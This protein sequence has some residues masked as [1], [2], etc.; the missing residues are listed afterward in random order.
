MAWRTPQDREL[1][2]SEHTRN[3][4]SQL[5]SNPNVTRWALQAFGKAACTIVSHHRLHGQQPKKNS[6]TKAG[7]ECACRTLLADISATLGAPLPSPVS[8]AGTLLCTCSPG[9]VCSIKPPSLS[10]TCCCI[11]CTTNAAQHFT[12][13]M[14]KHPAC[15]LPASLPEHPVRLHVPLFSPCVGPTVAGTHMLTCRLLQSEFV[16]TLD[17]QYLSKRALQQPGNGSPRRLGPASGGEAAPSRNPPGFGT[18]QGDEPVHS[19]SLSGFGR[20]QGAHAVHSGSPLGFGRL[21]AEDATS[22]L[23][24]SGSGRPQAAAGEVLTSCGIYRPLRGAW[25]LSWPT[26]KAVLWLLRASASQRAC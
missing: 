24:P 19:S 15:L 8:Q 9:H 2:V 25:G 22:I 14:A 23:S 26:M 11:E 3:V 4:L 13:L 7:P 18:T 12:T 17:R 20:P 1:L 10:T 6:V 5:Q 21:H 16:R